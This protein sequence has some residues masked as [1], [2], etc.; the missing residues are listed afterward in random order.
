MFKKN[1]IKK[2]LPIVLFL[3]VIINLSFGAEPD[4][5]AMLEEI[6]RTGNFDN[7][8]FS[9]V[10]TIVSEKPGEETSLTQA[11]MFRRD[12]TDQ[13]VLLILKPDTQ[14]GQGYLQMDEN[15]WFYD[16]ESR[17]FSY[18]SMK[19]NIQNSDTKNSDLNRNS[20]AED[21]D[22][23]GW[24]ETKLG[25]FAV[26]LLDLTARHNEVSYPKMK[27]WIRKDR[28]LVLKA[29]EYSLSDRLMRTVYYPKYVQVGDQYL[30]SQM[31]FVD[32]LKEGEKTQLT[33]KD[34]SVAPLP[35][36]VFTKAFLERVNN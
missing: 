33:M 7:Y 22:V 26:Y 19:E 24:T 12:R 27:I 28:P 4:F 16:P 31:L 2:S 23:T 25:N 3:S 15:V 21:Y 1:L 17:K 30:P 9:C 10:Y 6:D 13:F 29:E 20:L 5:H 34:A 11:R 35:D 32:N 18:S 8:D 14:K 36:S